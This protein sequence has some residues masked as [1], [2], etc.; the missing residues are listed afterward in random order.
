MKHGEVRFL[1]CM[2]VLSLT[3]LAL[4]AIH[5]LTESVIVSGNSES[6]ALIILDAGHGGTDGGSSAAD[7]TLES[8]INLEVTL[9]TDAILGLMGEQTLLVRDKDTDLSSDDAKTIA[10]KKISDIRNRVD[11]VNSYPNA[12]LISIHQNTFPEEK[13]HGAQVFYSKIANSKSLAELLQ[14]NLRSY[15]DPSNQRNAKEISADVYLMN[16]IQ[17]PGVLVECGFLTNPEEAAKL[18]TAEYQ[19]QLA[20]TIATTVSNYLSEENS[21]V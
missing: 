5:S 12:I 4:F 7:G 13:Y 15:V 2:Y 6:D 18:K 17:V 8:D 11:L 21:G 19:K 3:L 1:S 20:V 16:H 10:Q 9:K 14:N